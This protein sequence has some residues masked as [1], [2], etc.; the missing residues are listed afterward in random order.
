MRTSRRVVPAAA[1]ALVVALAVVGC[2]TDDSYPSESAQTTTEAARE[3][4]PPTGT[5]ESEPGPAGTETQ[6]TEAQGTETTDGIPAYQPSTLVSRAIGSA[7]LTTSDPIEQ[8]STF[9]L[10][11][12]DREGWQTVSES[13]TPYSTSLT[14]RKPG[15][16]ASISV[17]SGGDGT[18]VSISTYPSP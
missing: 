15:K 4:A 12:V 10:D 2:G 8:V 11:F 14:I 16:G 13:V 18:L 5:A 17:S 9:Y 7:V 1:A 6:G 3:T